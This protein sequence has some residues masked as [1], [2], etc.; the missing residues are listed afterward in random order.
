MSYIDDL[1]EVHFGSVS[2][3]PED[4]RKDAGAEDDNDEDE[5]IETPEHV[6]EMLGFDPDEEGAETAEG[7]QS[8]NDASARR[9]LMQNILEELKDI[10]NNYENSVK[11]QVPVVEHDGPSESSVNA[12]NTGG[13]TYKGYN[14]KQDHEGLFNVY[15]IGGSLV[16]S[17]MQT[18]ELA[19]SRINE[20]A[21]KGSE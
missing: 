8:T 20:I 12:G 11:Q 10:R 18:L 2:D 9:L 14:V 21:I 1:P 16:A 13:V 6:K 4:W 17:R 5:D 15:S 19:L 7:E 3:E